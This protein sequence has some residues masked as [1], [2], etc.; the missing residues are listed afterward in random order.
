MSNAA[1]TFVYNEKVNLPIWINYYGKLFGY[2]NLYVIDQSSD[3]GSTDDLGEVNRIK[4]PRPYFD[5]DVKTHI[6][7]SMQ[8]AL[9]S[10][11]DAV[12]ISDADEIIVADPA[13]FTDLNDFIA[14]MDG[15]YFNAIGIDVIHVLNKEMPLDLSRSILSQRSYGR[16][17]AAECKQLLSHVPIRWLPG[18][19]ASDKPARF[20]PRLFLFHLKL[21]DYGFAMDRH[22]INRETKWS[23]ASMALGYGRH[24]RWEVQQFVQQSFFAPLDMVNNNRVSE[25]EF[26]KQVEDIMARTVRDANGFY[27]LPMDLSNMIK[28]PERFAGVL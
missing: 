11:H 22:R 24:H 12:I 4:I 18:L 20:D 17:S 23:E 15:D 3:D 10:A 19:H 8:S 13:H 28:I 25:F 14:R 5:E 9:T 27:R 6:M 2:S 7:S 26:T 21:M 1:V 16:F